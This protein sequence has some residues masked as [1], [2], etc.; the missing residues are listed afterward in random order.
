MVGREDPKFERGHCG[1]IGEAPQIGF[2]QCAG[3]VRIV[4]ASTAFRS[5]ACVAFTPIVPTVAGHPYRLHNSRQLKSLYAT[6]DLGF[7][8]DRACD[9]W[10]GQG[11]AGMA[12]VRL[13]GKNE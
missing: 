12:R 2:A 1:S 11:F 5:I 8:N 9:A 3:V 13:R 10:I 4:I 6:Y 7:Q